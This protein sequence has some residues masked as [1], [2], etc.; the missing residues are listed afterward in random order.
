METGLDWLINFKSD[1]KSCARDR[2]DTTV[3]SGL[4]KNET[5]AKRSHG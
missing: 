1:N 5:E 4:V 2:N 3:R